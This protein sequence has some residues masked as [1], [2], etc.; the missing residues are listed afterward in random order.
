MADEEPKSY[1]DIVRPK[2]YGCRCNENC[3]C[4]SKGKVNYQYKPC[5]E[6][7][8]ADVLERAWTIRTFEIDTSWKR[9]NYFSIMVGALFIGYYTITKNDNANNYFS[10]DPSFFVT[11]L[12]TLLGFIASLTWFFVNK[13][14]K[15]W[16]ENWEI[17]IDEIESATKHNKVHSNVF[18]KNKYSAFHPTK[19]YPFSVSKLNMIFSAIVTIS[20]GGLFI[21]EFYKEFD[22]LK[23]NLKCIMHKVLEDINLFLTIILF[24]TP[25]LVLLVIAL[26]IWH[27]GRSQYKKEDLITV[28]GEKGISYYP[29]KNDNNKEKTDSFWKIFVAIV[30]LLSALGLF[31]I[32]SQY[33]PT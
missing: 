11:I 16:Q 4:K 24:I 13:G 33:P 6:N 31:C 19:T 10:N 22:I 26:S 25:L 27:M 32:I 18:T 23:C 30:L 28:T 5:D 20:W 21:Y 15:F 2:S 12:I 3:E 9:T 7:K 14:S 17:N 29:P 8:W 1:E